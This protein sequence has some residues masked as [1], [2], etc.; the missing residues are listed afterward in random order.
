M[1]KTLM[2]IGFAFAACAAF[3]WPLHDEV[4]KAKPIVEELMAS[5]SKLKP[6]EAAEA[7]ILLAHDAKGEAAKFLLLRRAV[8][9][10]AK[11][12]DDDKTAAVFQKLLK[13]VKGVPPAVQERILLAA[14]RALPTGKRAKTETIFKGVRA[15]V[16]AEKE[17]NAA[18]MTLKSTKKDAPKAHLRAGNA[19]AVMGDWT[20]ALDHLLGAK[21]EIASTADGE[22]NGSATAEKLA[23][24][25]WKLA[26][27]AENEYVKNAYRLHSVEF[28]RKALKA[29]LLDGLNK[30]LAESRIAEVEKDDAN[31]AAAQLAALNRKE[32]LYCVIDLSGGPSASSYPV[33]FVSDV[34]AVPGGTFNTDEYKTT[35]LVLRRI[36]PGKFMMQGKYEVTLTKPYYI[37]IFE[38]TQKQHELVVGG[39]TSQGLGDTCPAGGVSWKWCASVVKKLR[40]R[41]KLDVSLPT[42]AQWEYACRAGTTSGKTE[43]KGGS[44]NTAVGLYEP[45]AWGIY[46]MHG[47][48]L[49][50]C[51][52]I[53]DQLTGGIDPTGPSSGV[54]RV[55][56]RGDTR[57]PHRPDYRGSIYSFRVVLNPQE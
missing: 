41:V 20:K 21:D 16:W 9:L 54:G 6:A 36:E 26:A 19:L 57:V 46:D 56:R 29:S 12:G 34:S 25:W 53:A 13:E 35:K 10:Y 45:N 23:D 47:G 11:A 50:W 8:E 38:I 52:D 51:Q 3:A 2:T 14:G 15:L 17:L 1:R 31:D 24:A 7:A 42:E 5:K 27:L 18:R 40:S 33:S 49:D 22:L 48:V 32:P 28:Y 55:S 4:A 39:R 30:N 44:S 43:G 37:G